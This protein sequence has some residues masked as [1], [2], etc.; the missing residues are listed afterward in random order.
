M[1][2]FFEKEPYDVTQA[3]KERL[4]MKRV[5]DLT[6]FHTKHCSPYKKM[7]ACLQQMGIVSADGDDPEQIPFLPAR[8]FKETELRSVP[9]TEV[10][11]IL[12]SSGTTAGQV[13]RISLDAETAALQQRALASIVTSFIGQER[14]PMVIID[15]AS[16]MK[17]R[18]RFSARAAGIAGFSIFGRDRTFA[19]TDTMEVDVDALRAFLKRH[20]KERVFL[21]GF[22]YMIWRYFYPSV[23]RLREEGMRI[24]LSDSVMIHG[25]GWKAMEAER[26]LPEVFRNALSQACGITDIHDYYGMAEQTGS[27]CVECACGHLHTSIFS[28]I[29]IRDPATCEVLPKGKAGLIESISALPQSYPGHAVL[30]EDLGVLLGEDDCPCGRK[31]RYFRVEGRLPKAETR[32]CSDTY[33]QTKARGDTQKTIEMVLGDADDLFSEAPT[34]E[35]PFCDERIAFLDHVSKALRADKR[36]RDYADVLSLAFFLREASMTEQKARFLD[37]SAGEDTR[38]CGVGTVFHIAPSNVAVNFAYS[39]AAGFITGNRNLVRLP[40]RRFTQ[41]DIICDAVR[42]ALAAF[43]QFAREVFFFRYP[44]GAVWNDRFSATCDARIVWGGDE[45]VSALA[46]SPLKPGAVRIDFADR[47]SLAIIDASAYR[48]DTEREETLAA[49]I[50]HDFYNDT[51]LTDQD[52]CTSPHLIVWLGREDDVRIAQAR[53][54]EALLQQVQARYPLQAV[55]CVDKLTNALLGTAKAQPGT[56][57]HSAPEDPRLIRVCVNAD[58]IDDSLATLLQAHRG[59]AGFFYDHRTDEIRRIAGLFNRRTQTVALYGEKALLAPVSETASCSIR[60]IA[61]FGHTMDF[62]LVWDGIDLTQTLTKS[63]PS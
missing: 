14:L 19:L 17:E 2:S 23:K 6:A 24:D 10:T 9:E 35:S 57:Q 43:P 53:F 15:T 25:G 62:D 49:R 46:A 48:A 3:E 34:S 26:V 44:R 20:A 30:T 54:Y 4:L 12:T 41:T 59:H 11:K 55:H 52:A 56:L 8:L 39:F 1:D 50:A 45:T 31:G 61:P 42:R 22:T 63:K 5:G 18:E 47:F 51:Y 36:S 40:S 21:F 13:S 16:V 60:R 58:R 28:D 27:I 7:T 37:R 32:G 38:R 29:L 33:A